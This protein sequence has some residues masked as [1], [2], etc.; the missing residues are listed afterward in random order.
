MT[1][2]MGGLQKDHQIMAMKPNPLD[3]HSIMHTGPFS[4]PG[5]VEHKQFQYWFVH[6]I[7]GGNPNV[8]LCWELKEAVDDAHW[9]KL[10]QENT[11]RCREP[12]R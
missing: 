4:L 11:W 5:G 3:C 8:K 6:P 10:Q 9:R 12:K 7:L 2:H 1:Q